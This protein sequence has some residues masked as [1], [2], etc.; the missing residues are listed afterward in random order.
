MN[1]ERYDYERKRTYKEYFFYSEGPKGRVLKVVRFDLIYAYPH[2]YYNLVFGDWNKERSE[3]DDISVTNNGDAEKVLATVAYI[4]LNFTDIFRNAPVY[5][6]GSNSA[7][8]RRYQIGIN[9]FWHEIEKIFYVY[10]R[11]GGLWESFQ[12]NTNYD[13]FFIVRK[14]PEYVILEEQ[15][16]SY[17]TS[18][19]KKNETEKKRVYDDRIVYEK[20]LVNEETDPVVLK[21]KAMALKMLEKSPLP[22]EI[23]RGRKGF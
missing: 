9:K 1:L 13:A 4:V 22:E 20:D 2:S 15:T 10:G 18:S 11:I 12:K 14:E 17:M 16:E 6:I 5:A 21:K 8:S 7:R 19:Q 23:L 3:I